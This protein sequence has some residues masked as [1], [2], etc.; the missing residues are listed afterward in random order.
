MGHLIKQLSKEAID[1]LF[2]DLEAI[3]YVQKLFD[4]NISSK[5]VDGIL[6]GAA[7]ERVSG[8][9]LSLIHI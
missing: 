5:R 7:G 2:H 9:D 6:K 4:E 3:E 1:T 8:Y